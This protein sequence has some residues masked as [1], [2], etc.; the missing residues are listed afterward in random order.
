[1][2]RPTRQQAKNKSVNRKSAAPTHTKTNSLLKL[3][4]RPCGATINELAKAMDWQPHSVRSFLAG[5]V[6]KKL[7]LSLSSPKPQA[8]AAVILSNNREA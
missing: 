2:F 4:S 5:H 1:M 3:L 7:R 8:Q 6:R